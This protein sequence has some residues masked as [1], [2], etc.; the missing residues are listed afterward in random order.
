MPLKQYV[1]TGFTF[2]E[3]TIDLYKQTDQTP[4]GN[5]TV[6]IVQPQKSLGTYQAA[7]LTEAIDGALKEAKLE[8]NAVIGGAYQVTIEAKFDVKAPKEHTRPS[9]P[10]AS[11]R[12]PADLTGKL[13]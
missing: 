8:R 9:G 11:Q 10:T 7:D 5:Y 13:F 1:G 12:S 3:A 2:E 4:N 6:R